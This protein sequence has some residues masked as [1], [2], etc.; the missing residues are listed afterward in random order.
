MER[1]GSGGKRTSPDFRFLVM[2]PAG[3]WAVFDECSGLKVEVEVM[4]YQ[5]GGENNFVHRLPGR[6]KFSN[7][8]FKR[9]MTNSIELWKW[10]E[11]VQAGPFNPAL[12]QIPGPS[13][14][15]GAL[16]TFR[17]NLTISLYDEDHLV[18]VSWEV[19]GA[20]PVRWE[21]PPIKSAGTSVSVETLEISYQ[22]FKM[23]S[24]S[25]V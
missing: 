25:G 11:S 12:A 18:S 24:N 19:I 3:V 9:G 20:Y 6:R 21:G 7:I 5:E 2:G 23:V 22:Y 14:V 16:P 1:W 13:S 8:T 10:C 17:R 4:E 15:P